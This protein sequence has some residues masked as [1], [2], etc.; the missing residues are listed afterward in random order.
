VDLPLLCWLFD[1]VGGKAYICVSNTSFTLLLSSLK[2]SILLGSDTGDDKDSTNVISSRNHDDG[3]DS[4]SDSS[5][6]YHQGN[7]L[8]SDTQL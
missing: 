7:Y 5:S 1:E 6:G 3:E 8:R 2:L 4:D